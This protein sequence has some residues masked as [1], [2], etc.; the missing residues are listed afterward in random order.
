MADQ[1]Q[2]FQVQF[3]YTVR[4][5]AAHQSLEQVLLPAGADGWELCSLVAN[6]PNPMGIDAGDKLIFKRRKVS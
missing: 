5:R 1:K 4:F 2:R 3:E 6:P